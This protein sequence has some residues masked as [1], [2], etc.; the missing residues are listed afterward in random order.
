MHTASFYTSG[1]GVG[2]PGVKVSGGQGDIWGV[3]YSTP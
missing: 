2:Y 1:G 3:G